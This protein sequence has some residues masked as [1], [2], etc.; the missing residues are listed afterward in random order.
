ML[1]FYD[2]LKNLGSKR[3]QIDQIQMIKM[4]VSIYQNKNQKLIFQIAQKQM[5]MMIQSKKMK[6]KWT[7]RVINLH[8]KKRLPLVRVFL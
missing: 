6:E 3:R 8:M 5:T 1:V 7:L 2:H 4:L